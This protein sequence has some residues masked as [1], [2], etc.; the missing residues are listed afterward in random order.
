M[1]A[2]FAGQL[3]AGTWVTL[4]LSVCAAVASLI[5]GLL[6]AAGELAQYRL[7]RWLVTA[8]VTILR[9]VPE[10]L[11][12]FLVYFGGMELLA[13]LTGHYVEVKSFVA[14]VIALGLVFGAY[15]SQTLRSAF[16]AIPLGQIE[17]A[18][19]LGFNR[20]QT[21]WQVR[22]PQAWRY[23]LPG[24]GN[25]WLVL[26]KDTSLV[27]LLGLVDLMA[28]ARNAVVT[29]KQPFTFYLLAAVIYLIL[30][31]VSQYLFNRVTHKVKP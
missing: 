1:L 18:Q 30:T 11:I 19:V 13:V 12:I 5:I 23:A 4:Q 7:I 15:A 14:G 28:A 16:L 25:L 3:L 20:W 9:G 22:L 26:L 10:L 8:L 2:G 27:S 24:L 21:F 31:T 6:C 17:A 29:T